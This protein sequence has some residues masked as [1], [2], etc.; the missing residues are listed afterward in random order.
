MEL[1][2]NAEQ[3]IAKAS[4]KGFADREILTIADQNDVDE[5]T[6]QTLLNALAEKGYW[7]ALIPRKYGGLGMDPMSYGLLCEEIGRGSISVL[8]LLTVQAMVSTAILKWGDD[9]QKEKYLRPLA[10][11]QM[12]GA[13]AL[14]EPEIGSDAKSITSAAEPQNDGHVLNGRKKWVSGGQIASLFLVLA[15]CAGQPTTFLIEKPLPGFRIEPIKGMLGFKSAMLAEL[16][17]DHCLIPAGNLLGK[18]GFGFS[19]VAGTAL[20]QGRFCIAWG[21]VGLSQACLQACAEYVSQRK[22]FGRPLIDHQLVQEMLADMHTHTQAARLLCYEAAY[23]K[24]KSDP[25]LIA[26]TSMAKYFAAK[27]AMKSAADA[28]QIHGA[29]GC[30]SDYPVQRYFRDAKIL[31]IIEGSNQIQQTVIARYAAQSF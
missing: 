10:E 9:A 28:V 5:I 25:R 21:S 12:L 2:L 26:A 31:E 1:D 27:T 30:S 20:D 16:H 3:L 23:L 29:N 14:S 11:G 19:H 17:F 18:A 7:G 13:F 24:A 8:S 6:S 22:Q 4:F 15:Q